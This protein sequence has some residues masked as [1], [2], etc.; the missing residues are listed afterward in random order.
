MAHD[1]ELAVIGQR[2]IVTQDGWRK[3][4]FEPFAFLE[5][6]VR[7]PLLTELEDQGLGG[8]RCGRGH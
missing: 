2:K 1:V 5:V 3:K 8:F 7:A 6:V 4:A